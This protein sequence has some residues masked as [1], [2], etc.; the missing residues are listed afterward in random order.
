MHF[1]EVPEKEYPIQLKIFACENELFLKSTG[2]RIALVL[3]IVMCGESQTIVC[4]FLD[5]FD[6]EPCSHVY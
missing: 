4:A 5:E 3:V 6:Y 1:H 2:I